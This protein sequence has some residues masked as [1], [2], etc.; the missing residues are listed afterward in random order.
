MNMALTPGTQARFYPRRVAALAT[1]A[2]ALLLPGFSQVRTGPR[3]GAVLQGTFPGADR[4]GL[5]YLPPGFD[6]SRRYPVVY[7]LHGLPGSPSE[8]LDGAGFL[9]AADDG[10]AGGT[11]EPFL[12]VLPAA[13]P[14]ARYDGEWAGPWEHDLVDEV[15]PWVVA[16]LPT[17]PAARD[18]VLAGLSAGGF[19]AV[20]IALRHPAVFGSAASW[21]GYFTPLHDGPFRDAPPRV[22]AANDPV[23]LARRDAASLRRDRLRFFLSTGPYHSHWIRPRQTVVFAHELA[24]LHLPVVLRRYTS[25]RGVWT[26]QLSAGLSWAFGLS[27]P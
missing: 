22:L 14:S 3:G 21:S 23:A 13:G 25:E 9:A 17:L 6:P 24:G 8:Y 15:V 16:H 1:V 19:G 4:P 11:L 27:G 5:V 7:L 12:G 26:A 10:I 20:D 2:A 18:R